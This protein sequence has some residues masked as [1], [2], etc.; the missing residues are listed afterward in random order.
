MKW[1]MAAVV[2]LLAVG[3]GTAGFVVLAPGS[4]ASGQTQYLTAAVSRGNVTQ[5]V[6][7][8]GSV[9][10][11]ATYDLAFGSDPVLSVS[12]SSSSNTSSST[13]SSSS[14]SA[15]SSSNANSNTATASWLVTTVNVAV[16]DRVAT[17]DVLATADTAS[18]KAALAVAEAKL[19]V[20]SAAPSAGP[21]GTAS[22]VTVVP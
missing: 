4:N 20:A 9:R 15:S 19:A 22:S 6:V 5:Q 1:K 3:L 7:A 14:T 16:G 2:L 8:T 21:V 18:A 12:S 11:A 17:G 10:S 13:A